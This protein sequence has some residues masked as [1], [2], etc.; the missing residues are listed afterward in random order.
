MLCRHCTI[1]SQPPPW[2]WRS[3]ALLQGSAFCLWM[4]SSGSDVFIRRLDDITDSNGHDFEQ[5]LGEGEGQGRLA[6][7]SPWGYKETLLY[8]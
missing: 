6:C 4:L 3:W 2:Q 1:I 7:C 5:T 8:D